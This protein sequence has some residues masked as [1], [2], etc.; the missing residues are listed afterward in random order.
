MTRRSP[1]PI[2]FAAATL[3][4]AQSERGNI[5]GS[6]TDASHAAV[7]NAPVRVVNTATNALTTVSTSSS[8]E[9]NAANLSPGIYRLE[10]SV[11]GFQKA[12]LSG[13]TLTAGATLREDVQLEVGASSQT[14][15]VQAHSVEVQTEDAKITT[16]VANTM[17]DELPLVVSGGMRSVFGLE[18]IAPDAKGG[19][20][21]VLGGGQG[22][23]SGATFDGV[24]V[25]TNRQA[26]GTETAFLTPSVES[27][28]EFAVDTNGFKAE[29]GQAGGGVV[30]F[31]S[32]SGTN[33]VHGSAY[34][35]IRNDDVDA[36]G[37]FAASPGIYKQNDYGA[38]LGGPVWI[39]KLYHGK[40]RTFFFVTYEGFTDRIGSPGTFSSVPTP[41]MYQGDFSQWVN[42][43]NQ[44]L[45]IYDTAT[46]ALQPNGTY[47]RAPFPGNI[48][49]QTR[50]SVVSKQYLAL[51]QSVL[52]PNR[53][54][55]VP[56][57]F[58][59]INNN[60]VSGGGTTAEQTNKFSAKFDH[61]ISNNHRL[62]YI[63]NRT[64]DLTQPGPSGPAGIP[65]PFNGAADS[66]YVAYLHR[67]T[68]DWIVTPAKVNHLSFGIN[69]F[70]K[71]SFSANVA[72][73]NW[74]NKVC[75][76]N[77]V[78]CNAN[79]GNVTFTDL[80]G[81]G[82]AADNGTKQP[83]WTLKDD[84]SYIHG[85]HTLKFGATYD[86]QEANGFG[87]QNIAGLAGFSFLETAVPGVTTNT[88]GAAFASFLLGY[89]D[90]GATET[91]RFVNDIYRYY[92]FYAQDDW[93]V[94]P[95]L[96]INYGLRYEFTLPPISGNDEL[97]DFS[98]TTPN[99]AAN[100]YPGALIFAGAGAGRTGSR[101]LV[102]G[103]WGAVSPRLG[104]AYS[105]DS[106]T[107]IRAAAARSFGR[108]TALASSSHY[109]GFIGQY[110]FTS[111]NQGIAPSFNWDTGLP[112]YLLPP[113]I[114]PSFANNQNVDDW[115]HNAAR[116][117][118]YDNWTLSVQRQITPHLT[119]EADYN[120]TVG[121][122]LNADLMNLNQVPM[123]VVNGLIAKYGAS[124][125]ISLLNSKITSASAI[126]AGFTSPYASYTNQSDDTVSQSLRA[127][128]Q[129]LTV[130]TASGGGDRS[131]HS[132]YNA[133]LLKLNYRA[134][135]SLSFQ[136]SYVFAKILTNAD[137]FSGSAGS[138]DTANPRLEKSAGVFD[139]THTVHLN[140]VYELPIGKGRRWLSRGGLAD[141]L[142]G[143]W[144]ISAVQTYNS[145]T[146][147]GVTENAPLPIF[148]GAN[149]P[150]VTTYNWLTPFSGSFDPNK[151]T[152]LTASAFPAQPLGV[153]GNAP[154][155]NSQVRNFAA[156]NENV[157]LAKTF[158]VKER[159]RLD[160]RAEAFNI[161]NRVQFGG[162]ST[163][164]NSSSFGIVSSQANSPRQMQGALK[165]YW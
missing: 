130:D 147:I 80:S 126:A 148:N 115:N 29:Y 93:R 144:R 89:A 45:P 123:S 56:G 40:N 49:P 90:T 10:V 114:N 102:P 162:P 67:I 77:A 23:A 41:Q 44:Q 139:Q 164:L 66:T 128:P 125:A 9:Y 24:P 55:I 30:S 140:T 2:F 134:T 116:P 54:G 27:I 138:E 152:Y 46:T 78:D 91:I 121:E 35:F 57:T 117:N 98:A 100:G 119:V 6:V 133:G 63:F 157:S 62:S 105:L 156:L 137:N 8:G 97:S 99:P 20:S 129:Y 51:A 109:A 104:L 13:V 94:S 131:G 42:N 39:P 71:D 151:E 19:A 70:S 153:L 68:Y 26:S 106:K 17:V 95:K 43:K 28:T 73:G 155:L 85:A 142:I 154:R 141:R 1:F 83:S 12:V 72:T 88:S 52:L 74:K 16:S 136:G 50:F 59:Y 15:E 107:V 14:V 79:M 143:G 87:E 3:C 108:V 76:L 110:S 65:L 11:N 84:L 158:S 38:S 60:Y 7:P 160:F 92:G 48:I 165:L 113:Q 132:T 135:G 61:A 82:S 120:A 150:E 161:L 124:Q 22:G 36:R 146:P 122:R 81:W 25:N 118:T 103:Y 32:K 163:N 112:P 31:A 53:P 145:G 18:A 4:L 69:T 47:T 111:P 58:G 33:A 75:I 101:T 37:F 21:L 96:V 159:F 149:R 5:T 34:D 64:T 86:H 127:Y